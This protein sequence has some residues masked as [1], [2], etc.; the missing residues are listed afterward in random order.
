MPRNRFVTLGPAGTN[1][2][3][4]VQ[5]YIAFHGLKGATIDFVSTFGDALEAV[6]RREADFI[7]QVCAHPEVANTI[8]KHHDEI[9]LVDSFI[10]PTQP[11]G[12]LTRRDV[13]KPRSVGLMIA[14]K[15]YFD[16][17]QWETLVPESSNPVVAQG[18]LDGKYDSGFT[19][20]D[21]AE[22]YPERFRIDK[23]IG[24]VDVAWLVYGRQRTRTG[25][26][27]AWADAP[28]R[29]LFASDD[30]G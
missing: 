2:D 13:D 3:L 14:T 5:R 27:L 4:A 26:I 20:L 11:M 29:A 30:G 9:F 24:S 28:V 22:R 17:S 15:G 1:H 12:V 10:S 8:E 19:L 18:L 21:L 25:E 23:V 16:T 6:R 7:V